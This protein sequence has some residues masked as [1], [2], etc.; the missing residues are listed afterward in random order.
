MLQP[1]APVL[2][3]YAPVLQRCAPVLRWRPQL[4]AEAAAATLCAPGALW[5]EQ[6]GGGCR[7]RGG[8][9]GLALRRRGGLVRALGRISR[10]DPPPSTTTGQQ[11]S[12][13]SRAWRP[14][15]RRARGSLCAWPAC[16]ASPLPRPLPRLLPRLLPRPLPR[17]LADRGRALEGRPC[18]ATG[19]VS[20]ATL[21]ALS[22]PLS[23]PRLAMHTMA[24]LTMATLTMAAQ[25]RGE[26]LLSGRG[27]GAAALRRGGAVPAVA[28]LA[29]PV[30]AGAA[31]P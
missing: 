15:R 14:R 12:Y 18:V 28:P 19:A 23:R 13:T 8:R 1:Y 31:Q 4:R 9:G 27:R 30:A 3:P 7:E 11:Y 26:R 25:A 6:G 21:A 17:P 20:V 2:Q 24:T 29:P 22:R 16:A 5:R 10:Y